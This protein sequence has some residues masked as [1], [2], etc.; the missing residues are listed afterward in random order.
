MVTP[1]IFSRATW[2]DRIREWNSAARHYLTIINQVEYI[3]GCTSID[4][5]RLS[6]PLR[7]EKSLVAQQALNQWRRKGTYAANEYIE[8]FQLVPQHTI[9]SFFINTCCSIECSTGVL[10]LWLQD[11]ETNHSPEETALIEQAFN[12]LYQIQ[13]EL[14]V[15]V[16]PIRNYATVL[17]LEFVQYELFKDWFD[18]LQVMYYE[19]Q[20]VSDW[21]LEEEEE[22]G[23]HNTPE[24]ILQTLVNLSSIILDFCSD[25]TRIKA[26]MGSSSL[27]HHLSNTGRYP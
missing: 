5:Q 12:T 13:V 7:S 14:Q 3:R 10:H 23:A 25:F 16:L 17:P 1:T 15:C 2:A 19:L 11:H 27:V 20:E 21:L 6:E 18:Q 22:N 8:I 26:A 9:N 4:N 24:T